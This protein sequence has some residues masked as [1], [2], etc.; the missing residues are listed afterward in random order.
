MNE[1]EM[2]DD[3][4][5]VMLKRFL[6]DYMGRI[7]ETGNSPLMHEI[8]KKILGISE[9]AEYDSYDSDMTVAEAHR[10]D[11][12]VTAVLKR[13]SNNPHWDFNLNRK[14]HLPS[15]R[16]WSNMRRYR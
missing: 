10:M 15:G 2:R 7:G 11:R 3:V 16:S 13:F 5:E 6:K 12:A 9:Y 1:K 4:I 8:E 14:G